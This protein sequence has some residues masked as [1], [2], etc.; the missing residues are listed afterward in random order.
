M[1]QLTMSDH[2][3]RSA[4]GSPAKSQYAVFVRL[5]RRG[6]H[7]QMT[8]QHN[9]LRSQQLSN[10]I[11]S[12]WSNLGTDALLALDDCDGSFEIISQCTKN[13]FHQLVRRHSRKVPLIDADPMRRLSR[14]SMENDGLSGRKTSL[15]TGQ[16]IQT[17]TL[18]SNSEITIRQVNFCTVKK[19]DLVDSG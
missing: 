16:P 9:N 19:I 10:R 17:K 6:P 12:Q 14:E 11:L 5:K 15:P 1:L 18:Q 13:L 2:K 8:S 3:D 7:E 4:P